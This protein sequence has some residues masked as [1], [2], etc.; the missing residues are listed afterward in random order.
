MLNALSSNICALF[1][2]F[3]QGSRRSSN[4]DSLK[5]T[6]RG[7]SR[8]PKRGVFENIFFSRTLRCEIFKFFFKK[9]ISLQK[10]TTEEIFFQESFDHQ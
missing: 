8:P 5:H 9:S 6:F 4:V 1:G 2:A 7:P 3:F 10:W